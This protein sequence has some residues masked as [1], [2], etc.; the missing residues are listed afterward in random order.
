MERLALD[1]GRWIPLGHGQRCL[2]VE[3]TSSPNPLALL[4]PHPAQRGLEQ[5]P[6]PPTVTLPFPRLQPEHPRC[7][8]GI[9]RWDSH[10]SRLHAPSPDLQRQPSHCEYLKPTGVHVTLWGRAW[11]TLGTI[12]LPI[13]LPPEICL[14]SCTPELASARRHAVRVLF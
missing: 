1:L 7:W 3:G 4:P 11:V 14:W 12:L 5:H 6:S 8:G 9:S 10:P 13:L 2:K